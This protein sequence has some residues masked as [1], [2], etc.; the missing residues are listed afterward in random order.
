MDGG[1]SRWETACGSCRGYTTQAHSLSSLHASLD[2]DK[3][4]VWSSLSAVSFFIYFFYW[5]IPVLFFLH[6]QG[7]YMVESNTSCKSYAQKFSFSNLWSC[8]S[9][10]LQS[11][12]PLI[13]HIKVDISVLSH[14]HQTPPPIVIEVQN[15]RSISHNDDSGWQA[16]YLG[17]SAQS[18]VWQTRCKF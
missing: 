13:S 6:A 14:R 15:R 1:S 4:S 16:F 18:A 17:P 7:F 12:H 11:E 3:Q 8:A 5:W 9:I 2:K 10:F